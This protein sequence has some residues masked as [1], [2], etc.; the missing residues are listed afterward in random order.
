MALF[1]SGLLWFRF[2]QARKGWF[3]IIECRANTSTRFT[4]FSVRQRQRRLPLIACCKCHRLRSTLHPMFISPP[5]IL[6]S[7]ANGH[8][9]FPD[10]FTY[11]YQPSLLQ[12]CKWDA[13]IPRSTT[14]YLTLP[15]CVRFITVQCALH[16][17][18]HSIN[19]RY[20]PLTHS[21]THSQ[22]RCLSSKLGC[23]TSHSRR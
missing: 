20:P 5:V 13:Y 3:R 10:T 22:E 14:S 11:K 17:C 19:L 16:Q 23:I 1:E 15:T 4:H 21:L 2:P 12:R 9:L 7:S 8:G 18:R 6:Y